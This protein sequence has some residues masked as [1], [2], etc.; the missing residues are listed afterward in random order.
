[1]LWDN[2]EMQRL[3][4]KPTLKRDWEEFGENKQN[5]FNINGI[6]SIKFNLRIFHIKLLRKNSLFVC[7]WDFQFN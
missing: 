3:K 1:M 5:A 7:I 4:T 6:H 2:C